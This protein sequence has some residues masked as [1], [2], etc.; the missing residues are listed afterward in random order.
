LKNKKCKFNGHNS[1]AESRRFGRCMIGPP[2][3]G[4]ENGNVNGTT[5]SKI[6]K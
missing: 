3:H 1:A 5:L 4:T 2:S 6:E